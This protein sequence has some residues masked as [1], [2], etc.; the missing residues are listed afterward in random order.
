MGW[1]IDKGLSLLVGDRTPLPVPDEAG[2]EPELREGIA[3]YTRA[4]S[5][6]CVAAGCRKA[7]KASC[8]RKSH[9]RRRANGLVTGGGSSVQVHHIVLFAKCEYVNVACAGPRIRMG[10]LL[11]GSTRSN[12]KR[13]GMRLAASVAMATMRLRK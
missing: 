4:R 9:W 11:G 5:K 6:E 3:Q 7:I 12:M 1:L 2:L 8:G 13:R 10:R